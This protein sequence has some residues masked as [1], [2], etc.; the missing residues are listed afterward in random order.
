[1]RLPFRHC[2]IFAILKYTMPVCTAIDWLGE[3][4][5]RIARVATHYDRVDTLP[6]DFN[7]CVPTTD[8]ILLSAHL[9]HVLSAARGSRSLIFTLF[10]STR[11]DSGICFLASM[12]SIARLNL[13]AINCLCCSLVKMYDSSHPLSF[14]VMCLL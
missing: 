6:S 10:H 13:F 8:F 9:R 5:F 1:M 14:S 2:C 3:V 7:L 4:Y 12:C 11:T